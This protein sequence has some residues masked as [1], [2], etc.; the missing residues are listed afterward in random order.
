MANS[1]DRYEML[2]YLELS[3]LS[4]VVR[5]YFGVVESGALSVSLSVW[6]ASLDPSLLLILPNFILRRHATCSNYHQP[7]L[8]GCWVDGWL[9]TAAI[10][11]WGV[12][13]EL[14]VGS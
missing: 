5:I 7:V 4:W 8:P 12:P 10:A 2:R 9:M 3:K 6:A 14:R 1:D 11:Y 13:I